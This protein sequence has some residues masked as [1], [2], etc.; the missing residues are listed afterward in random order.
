MFHRCSGRPIHRMCRCGPRRCS[1][2]SAVLVWCID[3]EFGSVVQAEV[4]VGLRR[5]LPTSPATTSSTP[6]RRQP[7]ISRCPSVRNG[8]SST[9]RTSC[10]TSPPP[11]GGASLDRG[12]SIPLAGVSSTIVVWRTR[13]GTTKTMFGPGRRGLRA[14]PQTDRP[15]RRLERSS[16]RGL[17]CGWALRWPRLPFVVR[18]PRPQGWTGQA[19]THQ[20]VGHV[21][22]TR[23][24]GGS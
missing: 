6:P 8:S 3:V 15:T 11:R 24:Q 2:W 16:C 4:E 9:T 23:R 14:F 20:N 12:Q 1:P 18:S 19:W 7:Q 5:V 13:Y 21:F 22:L 10:R 17:G